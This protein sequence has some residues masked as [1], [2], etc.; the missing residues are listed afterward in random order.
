MP[1]EGQHDPKELRV[2]QATPQKET[3]EMSTA[4]ITA[5][6]Q[7]PERKKLSKPAGSL[8]S[9]NIGIKTTLNPP[10]TKTSAQQAGLLEE[11]NEAYSFE[12]LQQAWKEYAIRIKREAKD[13][14]YATIIGCDL[15]LNSEHQITLKLQNSVQAA[16]IDKEKNELLRYLR[17]QLK[18]TNVQLKYDLEE[19]TTKVVMDSKGTFDKLAEENSSLNKF[20]KL[21][22]LDIEY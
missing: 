10:K 7:K 14:L 11:R 3:V 5:I 18:N 9:S 20:R 22:N 8:L 1:Y 13:S 2:A 4:Q 6:N 12:Q 17:I 15:N 16:E 21:F 19:T